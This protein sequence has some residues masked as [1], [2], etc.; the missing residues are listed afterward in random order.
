MQ[1][2]DVLL[3]DP[4]WE[5]SNKQNNDPARGG[6]TYNTLSMQD[7]YNLPM[8]NRV[9]D[10]AMMFCWVTSPKCLDSGP[11]VVDI[12][13]KWGFTPV[14]F[15]FVWVKTTKNGVAISDET[16]LEEYSSWYSGLGSY[17]NTNVEMCILA[18]RGKTLPRKQKNI[19]QLLFAP[20]GAHSAKPKEQYTR[21][22]SL[23]DGDKVELFARKQNPPP[24]HW[25]ATG[26]DYDGVDVREW[27]TQ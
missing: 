4:P 18:R 21:I 14:T 20:L 26:L 3:L 8:Q 11:S 6:I 13:K 27:L 12:I 1:K 2:Y 24:S 16:N 19:K 9:K 25:H 17:T 23:Y 5:Y 10:N 7:L 22:D 15:A